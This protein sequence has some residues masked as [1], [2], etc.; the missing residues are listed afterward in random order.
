MVF[1]DIC[2]NFIV[3][4]LIFVTVYSVTQIKECVVKTRLLPNNNLFLI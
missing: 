4:G 1:I 3:H 2:Y